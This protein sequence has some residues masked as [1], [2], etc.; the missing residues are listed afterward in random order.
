MMSVMASCEKFGSD[1]EAPSVQVTVSPENPKV[2]DEVTITIS[3]DAQYLSL[4]TGDEGKMFERSRV[5]A[6]M[7]ND[8]NSFYE[9]GYRVSYAKNGEKTLFYKYF[10]NYQTVEEV[11]K[12]FEFFGAIENIQLIPYKKG[13]FPEALMEMSYIGTNQLKFTVSDRRIPSGI[14][15][16]PDIHILGGLDNQPGNTVIESRFVACDA[17]RAIRKYSNDP[18]VAAYFGLHTEQLADFAGHAAGYKYSTLMDE[19]SYGAFQTNDPISG[20]PTEGFYKLG[21]MY[22]RDS[23]LQQF[24]N[25]GEKI[26]LR[27]VD[28]Y[29]NGRSTYAAADDSPYKYDLDRDGIDEAYE[30]ELNPATGLPVHEAD[31]AKYRGFQGDVYLSFIEMGTDEY[32]PWHTGVSLGSVYATG[33]IQKTYKYIYTEPGEFTITAVATNVGD[34]NYSGIDY[35]DQRS[36]SL[37]DYAHK[38]SLSTFKITVKN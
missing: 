36:N 19:R 34:K 11:K 14:R 5:K 17:D 18:W 30:C 9:K 20:R 1:V 32:E 23:Y 6:I 28:M 12:D 26:V 7:E 38:R 22:N 13:D 4:F 27:Q 16:K 10:K 8:W 35:S 24:L 37:N 25:D 3:T 31:Y 2:G 29:V 33:G 15:M 21:E